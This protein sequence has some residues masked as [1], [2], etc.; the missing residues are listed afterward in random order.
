MNKLDQVRELFV[1]GEVIVCTENTYNPAR[2]GSRWLVGEVGKTVWFPADGGSWRG[3]FPTRVGD[4]VAVDED[5]ATWKI[6]D[7]NTVTYAKATSQ[8]ALD[9]VA[10]MVAA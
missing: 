10:Q 1:P 7:E 4:V 5:S 3:S 2:N 8:F 9:A 6:R